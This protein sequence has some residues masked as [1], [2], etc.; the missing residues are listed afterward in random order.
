ML[1]PASGRQS[2]HGEPAEVAGE[3][4][5]VPPLLGSSQRLLNR[6]HAAVYY[7]AGTSA[8]QRPSYR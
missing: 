1:L 4:A 7:K 5:L 3:L 2:P 6:D 8:T